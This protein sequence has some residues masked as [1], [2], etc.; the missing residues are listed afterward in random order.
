MSFLKR[1]LF[2]SEKELV[3]TIVIALQKSM[4]F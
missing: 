3:I 4:Y 1:Y 2:Y